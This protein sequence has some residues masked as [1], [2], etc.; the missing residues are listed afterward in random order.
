MLPALILSLL[1]RRLLTLAA[2]HPAHHSLRMS[3]SLKFASFSSP[4]PQPLLLLI[5]APP[6][7]LHHFEQLLPLLSDAPLMPQSYA[8]D[9]L[10]TTSLSVYLPARD[11]HAAPHLVFH[12]LLWWSDSGATRLAENPSAEL[13][14]WES[15]PA[16]P[17]QADL[18][19]CSVCKLVS[20][21]E[22]QRLINSPQRI[23][24]GAAVTHIWWVF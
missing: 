5:A 15:V 12:V 18:W 24:R 14:P 11:S 10:T 1:L 16:L 8:A 7:T 9:T 20:A 19:C 4:S 13:H 17:E 21:C 3:C 6:P 23:A 22:P 2:N